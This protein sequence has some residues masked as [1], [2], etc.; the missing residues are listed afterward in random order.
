MMKKLRFRIPPIIFVLLSFLSIYLTSVY[1]PKVTD[2]YFLKLCMFGAFFLSGLVFLLL[3]FLQFQKHKTTVDPRY[4]QKSCFLVCSGIYKVSRNPMYVGFL[5]ILIAFCFYWGSWP[6]II[7]LYLFYL[8]ITHL[9]IKG[10][11]EC[12]EQKF[13]D[14]YKEYCKRVH[15]WLLF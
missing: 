3:A 9:Q 1:G 11:E 12:L 15:R 7:Y 10:E 8:A 2:H 13:G 4:P 14:D 6:S 5:F